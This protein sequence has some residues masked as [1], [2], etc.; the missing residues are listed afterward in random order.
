MLG[1]VAIAEF[2]HRKSWAVTSKVLLVV[3]GAISL[4]IVAVAFTRNTVFFL[5]FG[6]A[7]HVDLTMQQF[8]KWFAVLLAC[9]VIAPAILMPTL[10]GGAKSDDGGSDLL[11]GSSGSFGSGGGRGSTLDTYKKL[12]RSAFLFCMVALTFVFAASELMMRE[13]VIHVI[14]SCR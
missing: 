11:P 13:Q 7:W 6:F 12:F 1:A 3:I 9:A 5:L 14:V 10:F 4:A 8:C 2:Y